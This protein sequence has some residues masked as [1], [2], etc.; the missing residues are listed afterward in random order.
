MS[1]PKRTVLITGCSKGG[2]GDALAREFHR[3]GLRVFATARNLEK[4]RHLQDAGIEVLQ[5]DVVDQDSIRNAVAEVSKL[6]GG[7]LDILVNNSGLGYQMPMLDADL[8]DARKLFEVNVWAVLAMCQAFTPLLAAGTT[9]G[10]PSRI[11]NIGSVCARTNVP[12]QGIYNSSKAAV[13]MLNDNLRIELSPLGIEVLHVFTGGIRTN[14]IEN[15]TGTKL[16]AG[17]IYE[18]VKDIIEADLAGNGSKDQQTMSPDTYAKAVVKNTLSWW[19]SKTLW[20]GGGARSAW[21][22][23]HFG[24]ATLMDWSLRNPSLTANHKDP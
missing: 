24:T 18:P 13:C 15:S 16:P 20:I 21:L 11:L 8:D 4:V 7:T 14:F 2:I 23:E 6:T 1:A 9:E 19:P 3:Q 12:W 10:A 22:G 17:S 5:L